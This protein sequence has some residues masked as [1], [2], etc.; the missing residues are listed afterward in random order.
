ME[1]L[2][3]DLDFTIWNAGDRWCSETEPPYLWKDGKLV[4]CGG[5]W[6][7]LYP[8]TKDVLNFVKGKGK[9]IAAASRTYE[10]DWARELLRKFEIDQYFDIKEIYPGCKINHLV[11]IQKQ[12]GIPFNKILFFDDEERN[13]KEVESLG[14]KSILVENGINIEMVCK[15]ID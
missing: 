4:D 9:I 5:R 8:E 2:V 12:L 6:I 15:H 3:F 10:P 1:V 14:V 7:R 11:K 13:I